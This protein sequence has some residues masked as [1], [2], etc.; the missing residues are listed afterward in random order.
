MDRI[1]FVGGIFAGKF[2]D[3]FGT[4]RVF[5]KKIGDLSG[6]SND[7]LASGNSEVSGEI[8]YIVH[9][10]VQNNPTAFRRGMFC[11][12]IIPAIVSVKR[13]SQVTVRGRGIPSAASNTFPILTRQK[14]DAI[15]SSDE[16]ESTNANR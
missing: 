6:S 2:E 3:N 16:R 4:A 7:C 13:D 1:I 5:R 15:Q 8:S 12:C 14:P 10:S 9:F 11:D